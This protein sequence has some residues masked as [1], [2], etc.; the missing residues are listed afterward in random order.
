MADDAPNQ[1]P[2]L[3]PGAFLL[4]TALFVERAGQILVLKRAGGA[5]TGGWYLPGGAVD[6]G[7][8]VEEGARRELLE[9]AGLVP[10]S[11]L[12]CVAVAHMH[13][14][15]ADS[16]QV[17]YACDCAEGDVVISHEHSA[18]R[19]IDATAYRDRYFNDAV[20]AQFE[21]QPQ[22]HEMLTNIRAAVDAYIAWRAMKARAESA[23]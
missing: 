11:P 7:E 15:G 3:P 4:S 23:A 9:E 12:V 16:L 18:A 19:W 6:P 5:M 8:T 17:L 20:L 21:A 13:V 14:Y 2:A 22:V 10:T 1:I